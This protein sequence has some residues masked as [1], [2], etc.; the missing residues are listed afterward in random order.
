[1][2]NNGAGV[3]F[4][5]LFFAIILAL[6]VSAGVNDD[7]NYQFASFLFGHWENETEWSNGT[8]WFLG[9][10]QAAYGLTAFD[11]AIH[12]KIAVINYSDAQLS[13]HL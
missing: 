9:L 2:F 5:G 3:W 7:T 13:D 12:S 1:M 4:N 11:S 10:L 8:V 6:L